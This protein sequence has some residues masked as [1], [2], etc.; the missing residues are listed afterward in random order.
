M[1]QQ[2]CPLFISSNASSLPPHSLCTCGSF[3]QS[4]SLP[5]LVSVCWRNRTNR[6]LVSTSI[7]ICLCIYLSV[8]REQERDLFSRIGSHDCRGWQVHRASQPARNSSKSWCCSLEPKGCKLRQ[9]FRV[10]VWS[11][12]AEFS[13]LPLWENSLLLR[14]STEWVDETHP[15][16]GG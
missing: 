14:P 16:Y 12:E 5:V 15:H 4:S 2:Y 3:C 6:R 1:S 10:A 8:W 9:N 7:S 11:L 13:D